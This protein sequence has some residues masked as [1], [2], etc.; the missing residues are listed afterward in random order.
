MALKKKRP[1]IRTH[2]DPVVELK[3]QH[4]RDLVKLRASCHELIRQ[5]TEEIAEAQR[6]LGSA[7]YRHSVSSYPSSSHHLNN[8]ERITENRLRR[9]E[10]GVREQR[11]VLLALGTQI[12]EAVDSAGLSEFDLAYL[13]L[14]ALTS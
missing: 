2:P 13:N 1:E 8:A 3:L 4:I 14:A 7:L 5:Y 12:E 10:E 9:A 6:D 11:A